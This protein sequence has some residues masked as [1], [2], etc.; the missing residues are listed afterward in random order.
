MLQLCFYDKIWVN[1]CGLEALGV[2]AKRYGSLLIPIIMAK[3][4]ADIRLQVCSLNYKQGCV[5]H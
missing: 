4:P 1:V 3:L 2:Y 5:E